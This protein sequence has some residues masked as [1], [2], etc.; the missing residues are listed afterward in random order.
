M[1][2]QP[3]NWVHPVRRALFMPASTK[4]GL[5]GK[6]FIGVWTGAA[7]T[8]VLMRGVSGLFFGLLIGAFVH[9]VLAFGSLCSP[10]FIQAL[11]DALGTPERI[12]P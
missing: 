7:I 11:R 4:W 12:D 3:P 2:V 1:S 6:W 9:A 5:P 10:D 8:G